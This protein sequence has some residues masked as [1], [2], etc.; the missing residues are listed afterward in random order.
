[1]GIIKVKK[2]EV[3]LKNKTDEFGNSE[4]RI[5]LREF[6][7]AMMEQVGDTIQLTVHIGWPKKQAT[8]ELSTNDIKLQ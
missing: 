8:S 6:S 5:R 7:P 3:K 1:M 4:V 2:K